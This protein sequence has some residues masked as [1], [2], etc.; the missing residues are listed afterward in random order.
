MCFSVHVKGEEICDAHVTCDLEVSI[1]LAYI[2]AFMVPLVLSMGFH[3]ASAD[4]K[5]QWCIY[6]HYCPA[7][8]VSIKALQL[9]FNA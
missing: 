3:K 7:Y 1:I 9:L 5:T 4:H 6:T 8:W 2:Y